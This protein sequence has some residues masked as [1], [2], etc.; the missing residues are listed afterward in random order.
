MSTS[1]I[2]FY[3]GKICGVLSVVFLCGLAAGAVGMWAYQSGGKPESHAKIGHHPTGEVSE[4]LA[5]LR[6]ELG[7]DDRQ[8]S[9]VHSVLDECIMQEADMFG[10]IRELR[11]N[12][13]ERIER[14]L[15]DQQREKF[16]TL[17]Y[18]S[19]LAE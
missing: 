19:S 9:E 8:S 15:D 6:K 1:H 18:E 3:K 13:R 2:G 17:F 11:N 12:G 10:R 5:E 4:A 14:I 7:L 16:R